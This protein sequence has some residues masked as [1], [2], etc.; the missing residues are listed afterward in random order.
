MVWVNVDKPTKRC[1]IHA[2]PECIYVIR[3][4][5][6]PFKGVGE[7]KRD[8]GWLKFSAIKEAQSFCRSKFPSFSV[9]VHCGYN[10]TN[11]RIS[12]KLSQILSQIP[13]EK[14]NKIVEKEPEWQFM[15]DLLHSWGFGRFAVLMVA[16]GLNDF[17]LKGKAEVAYWPKIRELLDREPESLKDL[18]LILVKF[19]S[20]ERLPEI[21][22]R[23]LKRF[24][25]SGLAN[26]LWNSSPP[27]VAENFLR[28]WYDLAA[29]MGQSRDRKTITFAMK[30]LGIALLIAG[31][32]RF[33]FERIPIP[34]DY[35]VRE[36]T[37]RLGVEVRDDEDIRRFWNSVLEDVKKSVEINMIHLDSLIWQ[38]G[39]LSKPEIVNYF[40]KLG[41][42]GLGERIVEVLER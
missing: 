16:A 15:H 33:S 12:S 5:E 13:L 32:S 20:K 29:T 4:G 14:W 17:Q 42:Q 40:A 23:R 3:K 25:S 28:I 9:S 21:K 2:D 18:E 35:R 19:Y 27:E 8:G 34:V 6:T 10:L 30:C 37:R 7:I 38:I 26:W 11:N 1:V 41:L 22:L 39:V 24:L 36:F 31:E